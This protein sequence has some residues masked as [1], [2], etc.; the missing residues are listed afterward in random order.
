MKMLY[1]K[2]QHPWSREADGGSLSMLGLITELPLSQWKDFDYTY[3]LIYLRK[4]II[5]KF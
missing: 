2:L 1:A 4:N 5:I 3:N